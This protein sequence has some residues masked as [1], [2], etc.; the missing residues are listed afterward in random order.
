MLVSTGNLRERG[1]LPSNLFIDA[2]KFSSREDLRKQLIELVKTRNL[3]Y[4]MIIRRLSNNA[5]LEAIR[6]YPDGHEEAVRDARLAEI[7]P[8]SF[9]DIL[10]VSKELNQRHR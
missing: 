3:E 7:T 6:I 9:K 10:A 5:A 4:G 8:A 2:S 1:V